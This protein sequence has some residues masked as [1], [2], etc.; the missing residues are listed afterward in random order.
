[1]KKLLAFILTA[2]LFISTSGITNAFYDVYGNTSYSN[3]V[4]R[5]S[6]LGIISGGQGG[7]F[8][9][10]NNL[11]REEFAK[12]IVVESGFESLARTAKGS[13]IFPDV[14]PFG[15]SSG[16]I[17]IAVSKG[18]ITGMSD[19]KFHPSDPVTFALICTVAVKAL[20]YTDQDVPGLWPRNYIEKA[21]SLRLTDG[22]NLKSSDSV[23][24]WAA[25]LIL[26][27]LLDTNIK[28][29][30]AADPAKTFADS[31][32]VIAQNIY[33]VYSDPEV[34][35][36][37]NAATSY[38]VGDIDLTGIQIVK[39]TINTTAN[40]QISKIGEA[41]DR[42]QIKN[43]DVIY[44]VS[45]DSGESGYILVVDNKVSGTI[46]GIPNKFA[47]QSIEI[48]SKS[49]SFS[50]YVD[51]TKFTSSTFNIGDVVTLLLGYDG[52][53]VDVV[54]PLSSDTSNYAF[55]INTSSAMEQTGKVYYAKLMF[56]DGTVANCK[57]VGDMSSYKG[58]LV[59]FSKYDKNTLSLSSVSYS[60]G[61]YLTVDKKNRLLGTDYVSSNVAIFDL[62]SNN[63]GEDAAVSIL[64]WTDI[65]EGTFPYDKL[66]HVNRAGSFNDINVLVLKDFSNEEFDYGLIKRLDITQ[67]QQSGGSGGSGGSGSGPVVFNYNYT[68]NAGGK[69]YT[70][71]TQYNYGGV[72]SIVRVKIL[73][74]TISVIVN[75]VTLATA[76]PSVTAIDPLRI[77]VNGT[78]YWLKNNVNVYFQDSQGNF[79]AKAIS[80]ILPNVNYSSV[81]VYLDKA[82][83]SGGKVVA[84]VVSVP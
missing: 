64:D 25:A 36:N 16:Y 18:L 41:I 72:G 75:D 48:N 26:D 59:S 56:T 31:T 52:K 21:A 10:Y 68:I 4:N 67:V 32:G 6:A 24:R 47:P 11:V 1:M 29:A 79:T 34:A 2:V 23:P 73:N 71:K 8:Y 5:L 22:I 58:L 76:S 30:N 80:D 7:M 19:G 69:D 81:Y 3:S 77:L 27:R 51:I 43:N 12:M 78:T 15:W 70:Y 65:P 33:S 57:T 40:P 49:Y 42:T 14:T 17:N 28:K 63:T 83:S 74:G 54:S 13:T 50:R 39:N 46:T 84:I 62:I 37:Y 66:L 20:G 55:V 38:K 82:Q 61:S 35:R 9:P 60:G 45:N 44:K 53:V